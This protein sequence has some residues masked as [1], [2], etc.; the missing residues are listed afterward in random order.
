[1]IRNVRLGLA[2]T[3]TVILAACGEVPT[4]AG[5]GALQRTNASASIVPGTCTNLAQLNTLSAVLFTP[6]SSPNI[7]SVKGKLR[8]LDADVRRGKFADAKVRA[9]EIVAFTLKKHNQGGLAGTAEQVEAFTDAVLCFAGFDIDVEEPTDSYF[10][11]PS[12]EPQIVTNSTG[13]AGIAFDANPVAEPTLVQF[14]LIEDVYPAP[15]AG[16]LDTKLDQYPGFIQIT[17][18]S[19]TDAPLAKPAVVGVCAV[20]VIPQAVRDRL[21]LGHGAS[22]GFEITP[23]ATADFISCPNQTAQAPA[24]TGWNRVLELLMPAKAHAFQEAFGGGVGGTVT[25]FS[26][27]APVDPELQFGGGVGGTVTEFTRSSD[28]LSELVTTPPPGPT[29]FDCDFAPKGTLL[30]SQCSPYVSLRTRLGTVLAAAPVTW[31]VVAG[32]GTIATSLAE[33][34]GSF[35]ALVAGSTNAMGTSKVCW[36]LGPN[37][38]MNTV[39]VTP[40]P[41]GEVP[42][43]VTFVPAN[44]EFSV[45]AFEASATSMQVVS[46]DGQTGTTGTALANPLSV[47]VTDANGYPVAGVPVYWKSQIGGGTLAPSVT[48]TDADGRAS[49]HWTLGAV[50]PNKAKA[51]FTT[52]V[53][54]YV[55]FD[56]TS[57]AP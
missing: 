55:Y 50:G 19:E 35:A 37:V 53:F 28:F 24:A 41:G 48:L 11:L 56:A 45:T 44:R 40:A 52:A 27:F 5:D 32:G 54:A 10:I 15:G 31:E 13:T 20:G 25:E 29:T 14:A 36:I 2:L 47:R 30:A 57:T 21:R 33:E 38:G 12:D 16:P 46:G 17:K 43:G 42:E 4:V 49:A 8:S 7:N 34:C 3:I 23:A 51:Y 9:A 18:T 22:A 1:M 6:S 26:P 39:R